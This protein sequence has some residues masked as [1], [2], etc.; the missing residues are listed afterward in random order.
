MKLVSITSHNWSP[1]TKT[2]EFNVVCDDGTE[3]NKKF[4]KFT[5][6]GL[7]KMACNNPAVLAQL[8]LGK[9]YYF[10]ISEA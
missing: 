1:E 9:S 3:E 7:F 8:E 5:P 6:S 4:A 2:L 10:D